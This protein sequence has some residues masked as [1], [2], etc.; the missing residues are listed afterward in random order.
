M[1]NTLFPGLA[2]HLEPPIFARSGDP[3]RLSSFRSEFSRLE[4]FLLKDLADLSYDECAQYAQALARGCSLLAGASLLDIPALYSLSVKVL[5]GSF[6]S[7][8]FSRAVALPD[9][10]PR[11]AVSSRAIFARV[12]DP[13]FWR[14]RLYIRS[15]Q[16]RELRAMADGQLGKFR[17]YATDYAIEA[18]RLQRDKTNKWLKQTKLTCPDLFDEHGKPVEL[19]LEQVVKSAAQKFAKVYSFVQAIDD[20]S[21]EA[22]LECSM[23]TATLPGDWHSNPSYKRKG[24]KWNGASPKDC[25]D[26]LGRR[27][28]EVRKYLDNRGIYLTGLWVLETHKDGT[29]HRHFLCFYRPEARPAILATFL[30]FFPSRLK[31]RFG[32]DKTL[33]R[34]YT[35][36][37]DCLDGRH[38]FL[39][40]PSSPFRRLGYAVDVSVINRGESK[41]ASYIFKY[42]EKSLVTADTLKKTD[43]LA[44][45]AA[46]YAWRL[47]SHQFFG[48]SASLELWDR[49]RSLNTAPEDAPTHALWVAARGGDKECRIQTA[50]V[51]GKPSPEQQGNARLF[52]TLMGGL[53]ACHVG[54]VSRPKAG[55][56]R[57]TV[58]VSR[59]DTTTRY[60]EVGKRAV[61]VIRIT[62]RFSP[63][64][65]CDPDT[66]ELTASKR[67]RW[68]PLFTVFTLTRFYNWTFKRPVSK[69][70]VK[71]AAS[72]SYFLACSYTQYKA[73]AFTSSHQLFETEGHDPNPGP[74]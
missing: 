36:P 52:I 22:G 4:T 31:L 58:K 11:K 64:L 73:P 62:E 47:R 27:W 44:V 3:A 61:G 34:G 16:L 46:R 70:P 18:R 37:Q 41:P 19:P 33:D 60:G 40:S 1:L 74:A 54:R 10:D 24:W 25:S 65:L 63:V 20:L 67:C 42:L 21:Q 26:E 30:K 71:P 72:S 8:L 13:A 66:G 55:T 15:I 45:D 51:D 2:A 32:S 59:E 49:L 50:T 39:G 5:G 35:S 38:Y 69:K 17:P 68:A 48:I 23:I 28:G 29:P 43:F 12:I 9:E 7:K 56:V 14:S 6:S 57:D 53:K